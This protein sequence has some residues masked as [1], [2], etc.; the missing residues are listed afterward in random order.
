[1]IPSVN[2]AA[3]V[4]V[5][6]FATTAPLIAKAGQFTDFLGGLTCARYVEAVEG[7]L[8]H[9]YQLYIGGFMTG[10]NY[11]RSRN[12]PADF[13]SYRVWLKSYCQENPFDPFSQALARLDFS[14]GEGE[15]RI[16]NAPAQKSLGK[17]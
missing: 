9:P 10:V 15:E 14:L 3:A 4:L 1:M 11:L 13:S 16:N 12:T 8:N 2:Y 5:L 17:K 7:N 6:V